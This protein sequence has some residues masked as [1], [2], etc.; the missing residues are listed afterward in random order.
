MRCL[1]PI[2]IEFKNYPMLVKYETGIHKLL[3]TV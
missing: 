2:K 1:L 3:V